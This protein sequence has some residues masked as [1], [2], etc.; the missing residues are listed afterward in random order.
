MTAITHIQINNVFEVSLHW[1][2]LKS[3]KTSS[4]TRDSL[5]GLIFVTHIQNNNTE[6]T[7]VC[8]W[9]FNLV[10]EPESILPT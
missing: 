3:N 10:R 5:Q 1:E 6:S 7:T 2:K 9:S 8:F 4:S